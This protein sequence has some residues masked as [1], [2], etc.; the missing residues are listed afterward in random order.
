MYQYAHETSKCAVRD[1]LRENANQIALAEVVCAS[2]NEN[3]GAI[4]VFVV[5]RRLVSNVALELELV[6]ALNLAHNVHRLSRTR[7]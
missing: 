5:P 4:L 3:V 1:A 2:G 6:D 7:V